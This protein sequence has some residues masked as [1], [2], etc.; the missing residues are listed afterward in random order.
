MI[1]SVIS[2]ISG[3]SQN[4]PVRHEH[5]STEHPRKDMNQ[6]RKRTERRTSFSD[7]IRCFPCSLDRRLQPEHFGQVNG[8]CKKPMIRTG[9]NTCTKMIGLRWRELQLGD[10]I[11][12]LHHA[13]RIEKYFWFKN[14]MCNIHLYV[15]LME[16]L[17]QNIL[18]VHHID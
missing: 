15:M 17:R 14:C 11:A 18:I 12:G 8:G 16:P 1:L 5:F 13:P 9:V 3:R 6:N 2:L 4:L 10:L 7:I